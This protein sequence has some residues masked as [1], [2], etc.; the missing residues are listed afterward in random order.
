MSPR[1][2]MPGPTPDTTTGHHDPAPQAQPAF[3]PAAFRPKA[4]GPGKQKARA[5]QKGARDPRPL[6]PVGQSGPRPPRPFRPAPAYC[7]GWPFTKAMPFSS[8]SIL[9]SRLSGASPG[10]I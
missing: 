1:R 3:R 5:K 7:S 6:D 2:P 10:T 8:I 9:A 4:P